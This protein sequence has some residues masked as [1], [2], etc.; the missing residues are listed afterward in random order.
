MGSLGLLVLA[1]VIC[2][3]LYKFWKKIIGLII[4]GIVFGFIYVV[5]SVNNFITDITNDDSKQET[6]Q[7]EMVYEDTI[8]QEEYVHP[9]I[10]PDSTEFDYKKNNT[11]KQ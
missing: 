6:I 4:I 2:Y 9:A 5:S 1:V 7:T 3:V 10:V 11:K 8:I